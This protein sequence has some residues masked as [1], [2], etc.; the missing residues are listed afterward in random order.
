[1]RGQFVREMPEKVVK[2]KTWQWLS[3][4]DLNIGTKTL[5]CAAHEQAIRKNYVKHL[6][7]KTSENPSVQ[8]KREKKVKVCN[9]LVNGF[10]KLAQKEYKRRN[11]NVAK[12]VHQDLCQK[13]GLEHKEKWYEH[14][15][16]GAVKIE[17]VKVLWNIDVQCANVTEAR[18]PNIISIDKKE[19]K[20]IIIDITVPADV[21]VGEKEREKMENYKDLKRKIGR[22]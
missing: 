1:M 7:D 4:S 18:R 8:I 22:L 13:N 12:K 20:G 19:R 10:E 17:E 6:I 3:K 11:D 16:E 21:R 2:D 9:I 15:P 14:V 5:L